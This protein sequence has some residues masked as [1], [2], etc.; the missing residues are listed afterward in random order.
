MHPEKSLVILTVLAGVGQGLFV[1][2]F[3]ADVLN[4]TGALP[5]G[6]LAAGAAAAIAFTVF[7]TM[8]SF[9]HL[10]HPERGW[11]AILQWR[12]SWLSREVVLL[13]AFQGLAALYGLAAY[14]DMDYHLRYLLGAAA[15]ITALALYLAS[16]MVYAKVRFIRE[17]ANVYTPLN[18]TLIGLASGAV[19]AVAMFE[20]AGFD[21]R[22]TLTLIR[23]AFFLLAAGLVIKALSFAYNAGIYSPVS[24]QTALGVN[25]SSIQQMDFGASYAH[26]N[27]KEYSFG[28]GQGNR[29]GMKLFIL[30]AL[31]IAPFFA[32]SADYMPLLGGESGFAALFA[33]VAM[34]AGAMVERWLFFA[35]GN[36]TQNLYYGNFIAKGAV[37]P[38]LQPAKAG[39]PAPKR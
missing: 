28:A 38:L 27:T 14:A 9:F 32:L 18:F 26:Y 11:K 21:A 13:P 24:L 36:H 3:G 4:P 15:A 25:S 20:L 35:E 37:N 8:A 19:T 12:N 7:G 29:I 2:L 39:S 17:W 6:L 10:T 31:F 22:M 1:F 16:S 5:S 23:V 34:I 30:A 33:S